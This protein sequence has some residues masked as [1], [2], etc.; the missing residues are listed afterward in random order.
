MAIPS[1]VM[2]EFEKGSLAMAQVLEEGTDLDVKQQ[3]S[4]EHHLCLVQQCYKSWKRRQGKH[5]LP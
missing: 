3:L 4:V 5:P 2:E 1:Y